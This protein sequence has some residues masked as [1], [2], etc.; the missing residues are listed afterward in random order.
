MTLV[1]VITK[2][3]ENHDLFF[4][5]MIDL[6]GLRFISAVITR[7]LKYKWLNTLAAVCMSRYPRRVALGSQST[8]KCTRHF[9]CPSILYD[10]MRHFQHYALPDRIFCYLFYPT[11]PPPKL[12]ALVLLALSLLVLASY[13]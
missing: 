9:K 1:H 7:V 13:P 11:P 8:L 12:A 3:G 10:K 4:C 5:R 6:Q 2:I